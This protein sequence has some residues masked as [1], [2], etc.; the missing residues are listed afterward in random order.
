MN[1]NLKKIL[2]AIFYGIF[3]L[4]FGYVVWKLFLV[5][6]TKNLFT[7]QANQ[8]VVYQD[9]FRIVYPQDIASLEPIV[10]DPNTRQRLLNVYES[11][12]KPDRDLKNRPALALSWGILD[13]LT[14][15]FHLRPNVKFHDGSAFT[16]K[17]VVSSINRG[18]NHEGS[19]VVG[20][21]D[22]IVKIEVIDDLTLRIKTSSP[23]PLL[24]QKLSLVLII[25]SEYEREEIIDNPIGTGLYKF[26]SWEVGT[27][28]T[29]EK[30]NDYWGDMAKFNEVEIYSQPDK[31]ARVDEFLA[32]KYDM[33]VS[34]PYDLVSSIDEA[35]YQIYKIPSLEVQ[36]LFFN[37][38][39]E[40]MKFREVRQMI[41]YL[42]NQD[43]LI[44]AV[45]GFARTASQFISSGIFGYN[46]KIKEHEYDL[47]KA[48]QLATEKGL[49][50][51]TFQLHLFVGMD[52]LG[53]YLRDKFNKI[54][55]NLVVSYLEPID[56]VKSMQDA[57]AD[58]YFMAFKADLGD[59]LNFFEVIA[60]TAAEY[61]FSNYSN[62]YIDRLVDETKIEM[63]DLLRRKNLQTAM[64]MLIEEDILGV[65]LF[66]YE[67]VYSLKNQF[68]FN[69]RIDGMIYLEDINIK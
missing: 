2:I 13:D 47:K 38:K 57:K 6:Y 58:M 14:W 52:F 21:L 10:V 39:S 4:I 11:L 12:I 22:S 49:V 33:L 28:I 8:A 26:K 67:A 44:S 25:P 7:K 46:P 53:D 34:V 64:K 40:L 69:P 15:E 23:D 55:I 54:G 66:E 62:S 18:M 42:I 36:F 3:I 16:A 29:L 65:P 41:S 35:K 27:K 59:S 60:K 31:F 32:D 68:S 17:D 63:D 24:L 9:K 48:K 51:E 37:F 20:F 1:N 19:E 56:L 50:G 43:E 61:N 30:N 5:D 45:G